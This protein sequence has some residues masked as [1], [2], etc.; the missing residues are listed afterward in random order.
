MHEIVLASP[1]KWLV[2]E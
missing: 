1:E 2:F